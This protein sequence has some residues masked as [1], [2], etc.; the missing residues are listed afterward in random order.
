[1]PR[2]VRVVALSY[3]AL[4]AP[5]Y[6]ST[7]PPPQ[8]P[9]LPPDL[10]AFEEVIVTLPSAHLKIEKRFLQKPA[11]SF[12]KQITLIDLR[13]FIG[14]APYHPVAVDMGTPKFPK[15]VWTIQRWSNEEM[16]EQRRKNAKALQ[17]S[18]ESESAVLRRVNETE[19]GP[20]EFAGY[21]LSPSGEPIPVH[22]RCGYPLL[23]GDVRS[24]DI[25]TLIRPELKFSI[26]LHA[27][28]FPHW[29][30]LMRKG[31]NYLRS[32]ISYRSDDERDK[33]LG[34]HCLSPTDRRHFKLIENV[35]SHLREPNSFEHVGTSV[36]LPDEA[37]HQRLL[38][39]YR[40]RNWFG[41]LT[42]RKVEARLYSNCEFEITKM[43]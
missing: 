11:A 38:M 1:M 10:D 34:L 8:L 29:E 39:R 4:A 2:L 7:D 27:D 12:T 40:A 19:E 5:A 9:D 37:G 41:S 25:E 21:F 24:C 31:Y 20:D 42:D 18:G 32:R 14:Q 16:G 33:E 30:Y 22:M 3:W 28:L 35:R 43:N 26:W 23:A 15:V 13:A 6:G 36:S 17:K